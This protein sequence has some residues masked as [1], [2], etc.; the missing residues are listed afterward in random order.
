MLAILIS[1]DSIAQCL[2]VSC[3]TTTTSLSVRRNWLWGCDCVSRNGQI[4]EFVHIVLRASH[5]ALCSQGWF[6]I[7]HSVGSSKAI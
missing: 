6:S 4:A 5:A 3:M 7:R 1:A 2:S